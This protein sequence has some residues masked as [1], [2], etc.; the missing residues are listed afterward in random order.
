MS[1]FLISFSI[2]ERIITQIIFLIYIHKNNNF[3]IMNMDEGMR[4]F[5]LRKRKIIRDEKNL[6]HASHECNGKEHM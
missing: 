2:Q 4:S 6:T 3:M 5:M 1:L